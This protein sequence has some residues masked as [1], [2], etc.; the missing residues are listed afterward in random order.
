M[1]NLM[2]ILGL[3]I[4]TSCGQSEKSISREER[5]MK[6]DFDTAS[7]GPQYMFGND[8]GI[9]VANA[10]D[11]ERNCEWAFRAYGKVLND[12]KEKDCFCEGYLSGYD[13]AKK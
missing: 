2:A 13:F 4:I 7:C 8:F 1:K 10:V 6:K 5:V 12:E 9:L 3:V 11:S